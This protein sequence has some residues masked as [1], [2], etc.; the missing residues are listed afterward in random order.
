MDESNLTSLHQVVLRV[1]KGDLK[2]QLQ[3]SRTSIN[4]TD[5]QGNTALLWAAKYRVKIAELLIQRGA[6]FEIQS[7]EGETPLVSH[8]HRDENYWR[9]CGGSCVVSKLIRYSPTRLGPADLGACRLGSGRINYFPSTRS[10]TS[11]T[12]PRPPHRSRLPI[13]PTAL[14]LL[15]GRK[16]KFYFVAGSLSDLTVDPFGHNIKRYILVILHYTYV[17]LI[18]TQFILSMG[19]RPQG[20]RKLYCGSMIIYSVILAH[21]TCACIYIIIHQFSKSDASLKL[22]HNLFTNLVVSLASII[23]LYFLMSSLYLDPWHIHLHR[24]IF[25]ASPFL[26]LYLASLCVLQYTRCIV[27][28]GEDKNEGSYLAK[29]L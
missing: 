22:G 12:Q 17:L 16:S 24:T 6:S 10:C 1:E 20:A 19:N 14:H 4:D 18:C 23:G 11:P 27:G 8:A 25:P 26:Y 29:E 7:I 13:H 9:G 2:S 5:A 3:R 21:S 15:L 28:K